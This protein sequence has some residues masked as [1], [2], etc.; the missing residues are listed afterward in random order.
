MES[1]RRLRPMLLDAVDVSIWPHGMFYFKIGEINFTYLRFGQ[2]FPSAQQLEYLGQDPWSSNMAPWVPRLEIKVI[3][4]LEEKG[5]RASPM[6]EMRVSK[7]LWEAL[8]TIYLPV[9]CFP[10]A[11]GSF[12]KRFEKNPKFGDTIPKVV[13]FGIIS[14]KRG[15]FGIIELL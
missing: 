3:K 1:P 4:I 2:R 8:R 7:M 14:E 6:G 9:W 11:I 10:S 12:L 5:N 13:K 15:D